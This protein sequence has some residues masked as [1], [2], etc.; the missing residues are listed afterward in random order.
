LDIIVLAVLL[1]GTVAYFTYPLHSLH[2]IF[3]S[4]TPK[5]KGD[6]LGHSKGS[7]CQ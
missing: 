1:A 7:I 4:L 5:Q 2:P 3:I 6:L